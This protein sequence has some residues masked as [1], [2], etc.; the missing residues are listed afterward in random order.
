MIKINVHTVP[1]APYSPNMAPCDVFLIPRLILPLC[2]KRFETIE[3][4]EEKDLKTISKSTFEKYE[5]YF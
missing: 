5:V 1:P 2:G 3:V 4:I